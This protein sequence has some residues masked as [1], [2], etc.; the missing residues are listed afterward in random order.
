MRKSIYII[1]LSL[2]AITTLFAQESII[3][4][5]NQSKK[6]EGSVNVYQD[7]S[8]TK[9]IST[10]QSSQQTTTDNSSN[11]VSNTNTSTSEVKKPNSARG[12]RIQ[13][14]SGN[15][16]KKSRN[17]ANHRRNLV[18]SQFPQL[19]V[20]ISYSA[21][22]WTVTAGGYSNRADAEKALQELRAAFPAFGRE[23]YIVR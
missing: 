18:K 12:F 10:Q 21:P 14:F 8:I 22:V 23:M 16:Q 7:N 6:G 15:D 17:E 3:D 20:S 4:E 11:T 19:N 5:L 9:V 13:V 1:F 2:F